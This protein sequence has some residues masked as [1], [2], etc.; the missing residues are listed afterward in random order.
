MGRFP[1]PFYYEIAKTMLLWVSADALHIYYYGLL[2]GL[3][4]PED[5]VT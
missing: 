3:L 5:I 1:R 2:G 4:Y